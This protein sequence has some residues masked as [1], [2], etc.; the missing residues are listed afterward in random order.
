MAMTPCTHCGKS[1][2]EHHEYSPRMPLNC[3]CTFESWAGWG[4]E[5]PLV[6]EIH[7]GED[8][9]YCDECEHDE[10]CH[11]SPGPTVERKGEE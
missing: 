5:I 9:R 10:A 3:R 4:A 6:C 11:V 7:K 8:D 2:A 1:A